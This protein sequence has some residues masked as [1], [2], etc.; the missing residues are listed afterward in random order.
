M[1]V[2]KLLSDLVLRPLN[3]A[4]V[5]LWLLERRTEFLWRD[6]FDQVLTPPLFAAA[7]A[8][9]NSRR[10]DEGLALAEERPL[11]DEDEV[12]REIIEEIAAFVRATWQPG[13]AQRFG[14]TKTLGVLRGTFTVRP[15][16]P[17]HLARGVFARP[18]TY[19]AWIRFSGPGPYAPPD[20]EDFG[21]CCAA[22][23]LLDVPG[24]KLMPDERRTQDLLLV[25]PPSFL[26]ANVRENLK[27]QRHARA[28]TGLFY[29]LDPRDP[30]LL[31]GLLQFLYSRVHS[32]PLETRYHST[33]PFLLGEGQA[34][35]YSLRPRS[36]ERTRI[37]AR[38]SPDYLREAMARTLADGD[39]SFDLF[40]QTQRDPHRMP[41]EDAS[42]TWPERLSPPVPVGELRLPAQRFDSD[43]QLRFADELRF[44][45]WHSLP[46]HR[47]LGSQ[48]RA[49]RRIYEAMADLRQSMNGDAHVEPTGDEVFPASPPLVV[50]TATGSRGS[51]APGSPEGRSSHPRARRRT[52][53]DRG[54]AGAPAP[55][56]R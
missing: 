41:I 52:T 51:E 39:W 50:T 42:V 5:S 34:V 17:P 21:Q 46:E 1:D 20:L 30:H 40:V 49:R 24:H 56:G 25:S 48:N 32:S 6:R 28:R 10:R 16:L 55:P 2:S 8:L 53:A 38:P 29:F 7:Q 15:D 19:R 44:N 36:S 45:P 14:Q 13:A 54:R 4:G 35:Q 22:I 27:L 11:P 26:T 37:P 18:R 12:T 43:E 23:K 33:V 47:P 3:D 9:L 31:I